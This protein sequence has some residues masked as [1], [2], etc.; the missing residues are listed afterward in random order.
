MG[1]PYLSQ[2]LAEERMRARRAEANAWRLRQV[3]RARRDE[4]ARG[5]GGERRRPI[6][7]GLPSWPNG[8]KAVARPYRF[9][10]AER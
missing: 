8:G 10:K 5:A 4:K 1:S 2:T 3:A 7:A 9:E 6:T